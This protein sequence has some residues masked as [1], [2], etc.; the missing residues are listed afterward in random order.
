MFFI[1][2]F[3][4]LMYGIICSKELALTFG[5]MTTTTY[6]VLAVY[7]TGMALGAWLGGLLISRTTK[8]GLVLYALCELCIGIYCV[9]SP[10]LFKQI[11]DFYVVLALGS[12]QDTPSLIILQVLCGSLMLFVPSVL[13]GVTLPVM[14]TEL[15]RKGAGVGAAVSKLYGANILG[16]AFGAVLSGFLILPF[17]G[18]Y[19]SIA[20]S[21]FGSLLIGLVGLKLNKYLV[22][23]NSVNA[24]Q[25]PPQ[26]TSSHATN[27]K[28]IQAGLITL[29]LTGSVLMLMVVDYMQLLAVVAGTSVYDISLMLFSLLIGLAAGVIIARSTLDKRIPP[30]LILSLLLLI[31]ASVMLAGVFQWDSLPAIFA[32]YS[33]YS[34]QLSFSGR[35][36]VR[37]F[38]C[39]L[40]IFPPSL[41]IGAFYPITLELVVAK[42]GPL[43]KINSIG[44]AIGLHTLG[45]AAGAVVGGYVL[46]PAIGAERSIWC[47]AA[48]CIS[49]AVIMALTSQKFK[50]VFVL[51]AFFIAAILFLIQPTSFNYTQLATGANIYFK[52][53]NPGTVISHAESL[54]GG[55]TTVSTIN[56]GDNAVMKML[57]TDG[58]F[59]GDDALHAEI[60]MQLGFAVAPLL[61][62][63]YRDNALVIGYGTGVSSKAVKTAGFKQLDIVELSRDLITL[64]NANFSNVNDRV[65]EQSGVHTYTTDGRSFLLLQNQK[66][67]LISMEITSIGYGAAASLYNQE[68]YDLAKKR[69]KDHG[70]L[71][72][73]VQLH[74]V[75][76]TDIACILST[77][78]TAFPNV[79]LY[80]VGGQGI[81]VAWKNSQNLTMQTA[82]DQFQNQPKLMAMFHQA[83]M[84]LDDINGT[85]MLSPED[86]NQLIKVYETSRDFQISTDDNLYLV[87]STPKGNALDALGS[88]NQ[89]EKFLKLFSTPINNK[90][91]S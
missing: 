43:Q 77:V 5:S 27:Q 38:V 42:N 32:H 7:L 59:Q 54:D 53:T 8:S 12:A 41:L 16:A 14:V 66:Y 64:A 85:L 15:H 65:S 91:G 25:N 83:A 29:F 6:T 81:I 17:F 48:L 79:S 24:P 20:L 22:Q 84:T 18:V 13:M 4:G 30:D 1:S 74:H 55:L 46:L 26:I 19:K 86:V 73:W 9:V 58:K 44:S 56:N 50:N 68:F 40:M 71:Q 21:A 69:L 72:Q 47:A 70:V 87:Y 35:E 89:V 28:V 80:V 67:D 2:G 76:P 34:Y 62:T 3:T 36:S 33:N 78:R 51:V 49:S 75:T 88:K 52:A 31:L 60:K 63:S 11:R 45:A 61:H 39:W 37:A 82:I 10:I 90:S 23:N 57:L